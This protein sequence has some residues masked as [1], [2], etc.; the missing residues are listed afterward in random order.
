LLVIHKGEI[1]LFDE[2]LLGQ[3]DGLKEG[4]SKIYINGV[5]K[6]VQG[7]LPGL[8]AEIRK[9]QPDADFPK[10]ITIAG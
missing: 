10:N 6:Y 3:L 9:Y 7:D 4:F 2:E 1:R 8:M 5:G